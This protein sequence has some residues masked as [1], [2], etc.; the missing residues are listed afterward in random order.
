MCNKII[1]V[2]DE[3]HLRQAC[4]QALELA[5][6]QVSTHSSAKNVLPEIS[7]S[8]DGIL[9]TDIKMPGMSGLELMQKIREID[10]GLPVILITG[11]GDVPMAVKAL[12]EG[13]YHFIEK[14]FPSDRLVGIVRHALDKRKLV[15]EN[16]HLRS[17]LA[18]YTG[19]DQRLVGRAPAMN[20]LREQIR[21]FG[22]TQ[23]DV[24]ILG[25]TGTGKEL[26]ARALHENSPRAKGKF[27]A[28][29]C[30]ALPEN[31]I[32]SELF[33]HVE[34]AFTG[35]T[36]HRTGKFEHA[37][38]GT[39]LLDEIESM[40]IQLQVKLLRVLQE[41][42]IER[43]GANR[44]IEVDIRIL[45]ATKS[46]LKAESA[47]GHFR[48]DLY[49]RLNIL[50]LEIPPLRQRREDIPLLFNHF[51]NLYAEQYGCETSDIA[52]EILE[53]LMTHNWPGNV[54]E[55][56]NTALRYLLSGELQIDQKLVEISTHA[57]SSP[58]LA[59]RV[60]N[61]EKLLIANEI[62]R[63]DGNLKATYEQLG[64][65]RK[66]LYDKMQKYKLS[67]PLKDKEPSQKDRANSAIDEL[68]K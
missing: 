28:I 44:E 49:Y 60:A 65:S 20:R 7:P 34:G 55:L 4:T 2:D 3:K 59:D 54:R 13:A 63:N 25:E 53:A 36:Q 40:P 67:K 45:A 64:I 18:G 26:V 6:Y 27:I 62:A 8:F 21:N 48:E 42:K 35:A 47:A 58:P 57:K 11:H 9:V 41:R 17:E 10:S 56:Q 16:R 68:S 30:G 19:L 66:T 24:L 33:G 50:S 61:L 51:I 31:I 46:D 14:P 37:T 5:G 39:V 15:L 1:L 22:A 32:E 12:H 43:L 52:T 38:G 23:A 29:N